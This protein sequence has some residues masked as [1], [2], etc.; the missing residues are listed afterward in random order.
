MLAV[1]VSS[2]S[3]FTKSLY[4]ETDKVMKSNRVMYE[5]SFKANKRYEQIYWQKLLFQKETDRYQNV[6]YTLYDVVSVPLESYNLK[7]TMY[8]VV[9][10][11]IIP[12]KITFNEQFNSRKINEHNEEILQSDST[13][14]TVVT[15]YD[16]V[17]LKTFQMTHTLNKELIDKLRNAREL[18]L[19]YYAGPK[20]I[21]SEIKGGKLRKIKQWIEK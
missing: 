20:N 18:N 3:H 19:R 9:D 17:N 2:C 7:D 14:K 4:E 10:K 12:I 15:G 21:T 16:M 11:D 8:I 13:K 5:S 6:K 1:I